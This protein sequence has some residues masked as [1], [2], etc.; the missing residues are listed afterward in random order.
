MLEKLLKMY[1]MAMAYDVRSPTPHLV[2]P[3]GCGKSTVAQ[4]LADLLGVN[5]HILSVARMNPLEIEG[6]LMPVE[7]N[8]RVH[9]IPA[10]YWSRIKK[11]D[12]VLFD[13]FLRG[14]PEVYNALLDIFTSRRAGEFQLPPVFIMAASNS[15]VSYDK[16]LDDRLIHV[17]VDDPRKS[18]TAKAFLAKLL[19]EGL[20]LLPKMASSMEM[21]RL[22]SNEVLPMFEMLD[23]FKNKTSVQGQLKG[24][25][26]RNLIG[27]AQL[28]QV[29]S[30]HLKELISMNN[31]T[32]LR[33]GKPQFVLLL[34]GKDPA[35]ASAYVSKAQQLVGNASLTELQALNL[36]LN[37][38]LVEMENIRNDKEGT[39]SD[40]ELDEDLFN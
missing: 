15:F 18:K 29:T 39:V 35:I 4:Q 3:P 9:M 23:S 26:V 31:A 34:D 25:S 12:I 10:A 5:L 22:L 33:K 37:L 21:E 7:E 8:T 19:V 36:Q 32:A 28:R 24:H 20:G 30:K 17:P 11:G 1:V 6:L 40:D 16:A 38:Q 13:E 2:G 14:F 27:Q